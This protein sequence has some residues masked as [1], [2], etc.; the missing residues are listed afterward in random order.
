MPQN[1]FQ[2]G[3]PTFAT[4]RN[5]F[6]TAAAARPK[7]CPEGQTL[8]TRSQ[9]F[10]THINSSYILFSEQKMPK[11]GGQLDGCTKAYI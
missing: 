10:S 8:Y 7:K 5:K 2:H 6:A 4:A 1:L 9:E 11:S 3:R